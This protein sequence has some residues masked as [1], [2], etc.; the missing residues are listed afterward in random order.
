MAD[1]PFRVNM[2][3]KNGEGTVAF[4]TSSLADDN[5]GDQ[6]L[7]AADM[8]EK[9][10]LMP[11]ASYE[12]GT[13]TPS[14]V[15]AAHLFG[16][17]R[18]EHL[19]CSV[20]SPLTGSII[21]QD[22]E[23]ATNGGLDYYTFWGT[24]VCSVLGLPEG[25]PI[26]TENFKLSDDSN[27]PDNYL[28]GDVIANGVSIKD[29]FKLSTQARLKSNLI[30]DKENG[31]GL[32]QWVSGSITQASIGYDDQNDRYKLNIATA[33]IS[34]LEV[35]SGVNG[36][37]D[38]FFRGITGTA[39]KEYWIPQMFMSGFNAGSANQLVVPF[40]SVQEQTSTT[41]TM[42]YSNIIMP[43]DAMVQSVSVRASDAGGATFINM[44][45]LTDGTEGVTLGGGGPFEGDAMASVNMTAD[46]TVYSGNF[47]SVTAGGIYVSK[48]EAVLFTYDSST[49]T[50]DTR[51]TVLFMVNPS[52]IA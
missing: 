12:D 33:S 18:N 26:Y 5:E 11:S 13:L 30:W 25:I 42:E 10:N 28:S 17:G 3:P 44:F 41:N 7:T 4:F 49:D 31:E 43:F 40:T 51:I 6:V 32:A 24:K 22:K 16:G 52:S 34:R 14:S 8:V 1:Y 21:F 37:S 39:N 36:T 45:K 2:M 38:V 29:T 35:D 48:G 27:N 9:I 23:T 15:E 50:N 20:S 46:D 19:S 47:T